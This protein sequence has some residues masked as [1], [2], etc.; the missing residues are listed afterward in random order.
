MVVLLALG[1]VLG[2][3]ATSAGTPLRTA[4]ALRLSTAGAEATVA[5]GVRR[6]G[7]SSAWVG[8]VGTD[9]VGTRV[10]RDLRAEGVDVGCA[11]R[12][13]DVPTGFMLRDHRTPDLT[14]VTYYRHGL[15]GTRLD[16]ED[17]RTAFTRLGTVEVLHV[18]GITPALG[19]GCRAAVREAVAIAKRRG[20]T[21]SLDVNHRD[22]LT[23]RARARATMA[24]LLPDTDILFAG[25][26]ELDLVTTQN[27]P[28]AA[29][30][31][32]LDL[33]PTEVIVKRG[34]AGA[35]AAARGEEVHERPADG[36]TVTDVIGAG[37]SFA[38]GYLA[39]RHLGADLATRLAWATKCA[40]CTVGTAGDWEG[41]PGPGDIERRTEPG[42]TV[43]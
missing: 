14:S 30:K 13:E 41:L 42:V 35:L 33:G 19:P 34:A 4:T 31:S 27:D 38:A 20:T 3:A 17:V 22:A 12:V 23:S 7:L 24:E 5:I 9:E 10:L 18:T 32:L 1:E 11:R 37:D 29:A 2:V 16:A 21:V 40:A 6:L 25:H 26:D 36:V 8:T 15:A 43:R 39:A 28:L